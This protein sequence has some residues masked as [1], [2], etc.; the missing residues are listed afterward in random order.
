MKHII[1][2]TILLLVAFAMSCANQGN[3]TGGP[4]DTIPPTLIHSY[5]EHKS[6]NFT[7]QEFTLTFDEKVSADR[8]KQHLIITPYTENKYKFKVKK[9]ILTL[10]FEEPFDSATTFT[11]NFSDGIGDITEKNSPTDLKLAFSTGSILDSLYLSG[12][13]NDLYKNEPIKEALV[14]LYSKEDT[15]NA[16][17][18]KPRYFTKTDEEGFFQ[19]ENIK[20]GQYKLYVLT[21]KNN[22]MKIDA[23]D[24]PHGFKS[25]LI[26]LTQSIEDIFLPIQLIDSREL[27]LSR[28]KNT[29]IYYDILY[30]KNIS[31]F[32]N[33][34]S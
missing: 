13:V 12:L 9:N 27:K 33:S 24:E 7:E 2:L 15:V 23:E 28:G 8:I 4:K 3:P 31:R 32:K 17:D 6:T 25:G 14:S 5:P 30:N 19:I 20:Q 18:G 22:N 1:P 10:K 21:D 16:F 29:G 26:H 11:L 34:L